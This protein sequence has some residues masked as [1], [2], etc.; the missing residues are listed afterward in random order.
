MVLLCTRFKYCNF[1]K[2]YIFRSQTSFDIRSLRGSLKLYSDLLGSQNW[3]DY[4]QAICDSVVY[5]LPTDMRRKNLTLW[6]LKKHPN[7]QRFE[8]RQGNKTIVGTLFRH[9]KS[10]YVLAVHTRSSLK[11]REW[12]WHAC[13]YV[14]I[15]D[16]RSRKSSI[17]DQMMYL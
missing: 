4:I 3:R 11:S 6:T 1:W 2:R 17:V 16:R 14:W 8:G 15:K 7:W 12:I 10:K 13:N 5:N 9:Q